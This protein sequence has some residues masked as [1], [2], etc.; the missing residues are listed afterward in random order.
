MSRYAPGY[1]GPT[2]T[3]GPIKPKN[4]IK[5][6]GP[7]KPPLGV[8]KGMSI[9]GVVNPRTSLKPTKVMDDSGMAI[10]TKGSIGSTLGPVKPKNPIKPQNVTDDSGMATR[11][12]D[13]A[14][15]IKTGIGLV[16]GTVKRNMPTAE[17]KK[18][19]VM[20][21]TGTILMAKGGMTKKGYAKG[22]V[23][24]ANCGA[25]MKPSLGKWKK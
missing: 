22:G 24:K 21:G 6:K 12:V 1:T 4:P 15:A 10:G 23:V 2:T 9:G 18:D 5:P 3:A 11:G 19:T 16:G 25:S 7:I 20:P 14:N 17:V 8:K 13:K